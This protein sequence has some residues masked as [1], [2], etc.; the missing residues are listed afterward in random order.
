MFLFD[1]NVKLAVRDKVIIVLT[2]GTIPTLILL[3]LVDKRSG[4]IGA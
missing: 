4:M 2:D 3:Q 1:G